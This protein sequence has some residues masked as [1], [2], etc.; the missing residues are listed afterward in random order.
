MKIVMKGSRR[1]KEEGRNWRW[2]SVGAGGIG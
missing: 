1:R 2:R